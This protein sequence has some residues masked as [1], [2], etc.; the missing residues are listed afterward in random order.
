MSDEALK[1]MHLDEA[2]IQGNAIVTGAKA[3]REG[4]PAPEIFRQ[5]GK[6]RELAK[7]ADANLRKR[8]SQ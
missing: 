3:A 5:I 6:N 1:Q 8:P 2:G 4:K 7:K